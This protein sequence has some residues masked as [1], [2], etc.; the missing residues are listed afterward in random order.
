MERLMH[1]SAYL[2]AT[3]G[4][5]QAYIQVVQNFRDVCHIVLLHDLDSLGSCRHCQCGSLQ[6]CK[7][8]T[9]CVTKHGARCLG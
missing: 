5:A 6:Y 8:K 3:L 2:K 9:D 7:C 1:V 4:N